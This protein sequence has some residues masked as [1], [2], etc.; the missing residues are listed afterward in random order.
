MKKDNNKFLDD[1]SKVASSTLAT[2]VSIKNE[3][4]QM[5]KTQFKS[6]GKKFDL[7]TKADFSNLKD[8]VSHLYDEVQNIVSKTVHTNKEGEKKMATPAKKPAAAKKASAKKA[9]PKKKVTAKK[10]PAKKV[11]AKK[12]A[13]KKAVAKKAPAKKAAAKKAAPKKA[14]AKKAAPKKAAPKKAAA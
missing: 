5:V 11:A 10:A 4:S 9:A 13:P 1:V 8:S 2:L 3:L 12:A 6:K 7:H 14:V